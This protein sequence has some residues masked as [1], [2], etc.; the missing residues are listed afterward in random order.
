MK[1]LILGATGLIGSNL[2]KGLSLNP[3]FIVGGTY[4]D[5]SYLTYFPPD[6]IDRLFF[7]N[8]SDCELVTLI[9]KFRPQWVINALGITKHV[10]EAD[11][12]P[13]L[14][15]I[16]ALFPHELAKLCG[17]YSAKLL[18]I[19]TDCVFSGHKGNYSE[20]DIPD[21]SDF[22]GRSKLLGE[23]EY[24]NHLTL[25]ISTI[26][27]ELRTSNGLL[28][29]FLS[30]ESNCSGYSNAIFS[31][32]PT[33][34]FAQVLMNYVLEKPELKGLY[35][36]SASPI[37]KLTLLKLIAKEYKKTININID[38]SVVINRSLDSSKFS[39]ETGFI[40][41]EWPELIRMMASTNG[42]INDV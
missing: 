42:I 3:K 35:H 6:C 17:N 8:H 27:H 38:D 12:L 33:S 22:Y 13:K 40:S 18:Q 4:R 31:G 20:M 10:L 37:D 29:W 25:R 21:A 26:G 2:F 28:N 19:S 34:Y 24:S 41:P 32:L 11:A 7:Y 16:N 1:I 23:V 9:K 36:V 15:S 5:K 39:N 30:Q 14:I